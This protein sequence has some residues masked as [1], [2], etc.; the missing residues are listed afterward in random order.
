MR[1]WLSWWS[2]TLPRS[3]PRVRVPS[4]ALEKRRISR[5]TGSSFFDPEG[6]RTPHFMRGSRSRLPA[7][8]ALNALRRRAGLRSTS[9]GAKRTSPGR[10]A[11]TGPRGPSAPERSVFESLELT[12][13]TLTERT[14]N[15][16]LLCRSL[17][18]VGATGFEPATSASRTMKGMC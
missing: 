4:R 15:K 18:F 2:A 6:V 16:P 12:D 7:R 14:K 11:P 8:S 9:V 3:R 10:S 13:T 1:E 17:F 5:K